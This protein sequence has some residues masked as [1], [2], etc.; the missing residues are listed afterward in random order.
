MNQSP[1]I[2]P[3]TVL[4]TVFASVFS[5]AVAAVVGPYTLMFL[6]ALGGAG[7]RLGQ[8]G[9]TGRNA[10]L[11]MVALYVLIALLFTVPASTLVTHSFEGVSDSVLWGPVAFGLGYVGDQW[12][13]VM[14]WIG[15]KISA[16]IDILIQMR[17]GR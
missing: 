5:P 2:G 11:W 10:S 1:D 7:M 14:A 15:E 17:G 4:T 6:A 9:S 3:A 16:F 8:K 13:R 12:G